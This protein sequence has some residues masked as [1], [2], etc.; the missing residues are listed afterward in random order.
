MTEHDDSRDERLKELL[1]QTAPD[2]PDVAPDARVTAVADRARAVRRRQGIAVAAAVLAVVGAGVAVPLALSGGDD[3]SQ[4]DVADDPAPEVAE[5]P[6]CPAEPIDVTNGLAVKDLPDGAVSARLCPAAFRTMQGDVDFTLPTEPVTDGVD[7][8][9]ARIRDTREMPLPAECAS[10]MVAPMPWALVVSYPDGASRTVGSTMTTCA[11]V[12][13]GGRQV[14]VEDV[15]ASVEDAV[16]ESPTTT[17]VAECPRPGAE[18]GTLVAEP[19][20]FTGDLADLD[21]TSGA[22]CYGVDPQGTAEYAET[23]GFLE[24]VDLGAVVDDVVAGTTAARSRAFDCIDTGPTR[25]LVLVGDRG[26]LTLTDDACSGE[27][28]YAGGFWVPGPA[29][30]AALVGA[31]GGRVGG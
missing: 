21:V 30:Q 16:G 7:E 6:A 1:D 22:V 5:P 20:T 8:L 24:G 10:I 25:L 3:S 31:L 26:R 28:A 29:A 15:I 14:S 11:T 4:Q 9:L 13:V 23:R 18:S 19:D 17:P 12:D 27:F 2:R